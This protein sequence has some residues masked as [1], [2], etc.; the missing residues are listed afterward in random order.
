MSTKLKTNS[1]PEDAFEDDYPD[2]ITGDSLQDQYKQ[3]MSYFSGAPVLS[4]SDW[5]NN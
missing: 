5:L 1:Y 3:Y 2:L 4:Y